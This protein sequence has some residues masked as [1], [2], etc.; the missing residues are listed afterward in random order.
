MAVNTPYV[1]RSFTRYRIGGVAS[2]SITRAWLRI[3][4]PAG[5]APQILSPME[6]QNATL[7][8]F[9]RL[10]RVFDIRVHDILKDSTNR[11]FIVHQIQP[12][13]GLTNLL[14]CSEIPPPIP[15][16]FDAQS[17]EDFWTSTASGFS[18]STTDSFLQ[19]TS[20][21][22]GTLP[23]AAKGL[24]QV[25]PGDF[26]I[27]A[28]LRTDTGSVGN[29][30]NA[31][32]GARHPS[33]SLGCYVG[34]LDYGSTDLVRLDEYA[35]STLDTTTGAGGLAT[36]TLYYARLKRMGAR[37][38]AFYKSTAALPTVNSDWTE[39]FND[40]S[41]SFSSPDA[42]RVGA[43]GYTNNSSQG[44]A[45]LVYIRNWTLGG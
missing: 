36:N 6:G 3:L 10:A 15:D 27:W 39:I 5:G 11:I 9:I 13:P 44:N 19:L 16:E 41:T 17:L 28:Q 29:T 45:R 4:G 42:L 14:H 1:R 2:V 32:L 22:A 30:R 35:A 20:M 21:P 37:F 7:S 23:S 40:P 38:R 26:D 12:E 43:W 24:Y 8:A 33:S 18:I 34:A 31:L 25:V